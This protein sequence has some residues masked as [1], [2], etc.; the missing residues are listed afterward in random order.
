MSVPFFVFGFGPD[1]KLPLT[2]A[3]SR[4]RGGRSRC[5]AFYIDLK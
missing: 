1:V 3:L 4:R 2:P 5:L